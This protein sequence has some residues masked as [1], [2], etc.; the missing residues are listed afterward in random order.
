MFEIKIVS[1]VL[2]VFFCLCSHMKKLV[3][4]HWKVCF[5]SSLLK[6]CISFALVADGVFLKLAP[7]FNV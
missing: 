6:L 2:R 5:F 1:A 4:M 3:R 7:K